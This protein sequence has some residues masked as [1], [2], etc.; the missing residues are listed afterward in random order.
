M[1]AAYMFASGIH[2]D[3]WYQYLVAFLFSMVK[4]GKQYSVYETFGDKH[5]SLV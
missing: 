5:I 4:N 2:V 3:G 1:P